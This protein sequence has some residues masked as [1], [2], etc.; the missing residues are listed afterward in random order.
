M[1]D[2]R[3]MLQIRRDVLALGER[4][5]LLA[6]E[7]NAARNECDRLKARNEEL[8]DT[9]DDMQA[10]AGSILSQHGSIIKNSLKIDCIRARG[11]ALDALAINSLEEARAVLAKT[12]G[13]GT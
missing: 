6:N 1:S 13:G 9:L 11:R 4:P 7:L 10:T 5:A 2:N 3:S 8:R 12:E